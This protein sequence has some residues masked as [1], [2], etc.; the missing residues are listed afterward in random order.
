MFHRPFFDVPDPFLSFCSTPPSSTPTSLPMAG[1]RRSPCATPQGG[2]QF[3]R[4]ILVLESTA[5]HKAHSRICHSSHGTSV[6]KLYLVDNISV[7]LAF[8]R[9]R[10]HLHLLLVHIRRFDALCLCRDVF[11][12]VRCEPSEF[13]TSD[14]GSRKVCPV[15]RGKSK[16]AGQVGGQRHAPTPN[17]VSHCTAVRIRSL[18]SAPRFIHHTVVIQT[19]IMVWSVCATMQDAVI[20]PRKKWGLKDTG[21]SLSS[22]VFPYETECCNWWDEQSLRPSRAGQGVHLLHDQI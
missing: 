9:R 3:G 20:F 6:R 4:H 12:S 5:L 2:L 17:I 18:V 16:S 19:Q 15:L 10:A 13:N 11:A 21:W 22:H 14:A 8:D 1:I 7:Q